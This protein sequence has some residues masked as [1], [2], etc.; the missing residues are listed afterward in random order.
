[1]LADTERPLLRPSNRRFGSDAIADVLRQLDIAY[2]AMNPGA[3]F[4]GLHDS[5]VN[6]L[7]N[8]R[9]QMLGSACMK[10]TR[11]ASRTDMRRSQ[12]KRWRLR[13]TPT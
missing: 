13:S 3:S 10:S 9:P 8:E 1:M 6:H 5:L 12:V 4:R 7:G 2:M 11:S